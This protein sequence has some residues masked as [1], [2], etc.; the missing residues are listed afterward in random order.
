MPCNRLKVN[1]LFGGTYRLH[2]QDRRISQSRNQLLLLPPT[3]WFLAW[4]NLRPWRWRRFKRTTRRYIPED[5]TLHNHGC[6]NLRS[7]MKVFKFHRKVNSVSD[8]VPVQDFVQRPWMSRL[9]NPKRAI[10]LKFYFD[11]VM[12]FR[13]KSRAED[14]SLWRWMCYGIWRC[15]VCTYLQI[16]GGICRL[17]R[18]GKGVSM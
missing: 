14:T 15:V 7:Y 3:R 6:E 18:H 10:G 8:F 17:Y 12:S 13:P 16:F 1:R 2:F 4:L 11:N 5:R 9:E